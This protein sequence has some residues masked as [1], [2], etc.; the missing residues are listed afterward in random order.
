MSDEFDRYSRHV[1]LKV[2]GSA[3]HEKIRSARVLVAGMGALGSL[4]SILLARAGV[5]FLRLVDK[6]APEMNN[7]H[8]QILYNEKDALMGIPKVEAARANLLTMA[9]KIEIDA[10]NI[11]IDH[12]SIDQLLDNVDIVVDALDNSETRFIVNDAILGRRIPYIFGGAVETMGNVMTIIPGET[13]C[14]RCLWPDPSHVAGHARAS[15]VGVLSSVASLVASIQVT[16]TFKVLVGD[17]ENIIRGIMV[18]DIWKNQFHVVPIF[19]TPGCLCSGI[20]FQP[21]SP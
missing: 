18:V 14:L 2:I 15:T 21:S 13:P 9:S 3:G 16:E 6:D 8:R 4:I 7:L 20:A 5:G 1:L 12:E 11:K 10:V 19:P 17:L